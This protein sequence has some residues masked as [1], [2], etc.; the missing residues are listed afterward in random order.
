MACSTLV[1]GGPIYE[2]LTHNVSVHTP[3]HIDTRIPLYRLKE[4]YADLEAA[5]FGVDIIEYQPS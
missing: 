4:A 3:H 1:R 5:G 2:V